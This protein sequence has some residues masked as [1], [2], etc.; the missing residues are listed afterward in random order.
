MKIKGN[1]HEASPKRLADQPQAETGN[2][3]IRFL[4]VFYC[5]MPLAFSLLLLGCGKK[6]NPRAPELAVPVPIRDLRAQAEGRG[7]ALT[8]SR[9]T[10]YADGRELRDLAGFVIF[11]K[12][13]SRSCPECPVPYRE[14]VAVNV[15][16]Q[17][18]F[19]KKKE[20]RFVD[21][22]LTPQTIYRYR[23][24]ARLMDDSL[25]DPSNEVEVSWRP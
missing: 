6:G 25:S 20:F 4:V 23:V 12:E 15:E 13:L 19:M 18:K 24:F 3:K 16:D 11:R 22:E 5:L 1:R 7:I 21:R 8:W 17:E 2:R 14:R 9:P 10:R